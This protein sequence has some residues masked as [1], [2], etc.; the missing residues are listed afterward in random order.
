MIG[1]WNPAEQIAHPVKNPD[2]QR[3]HNNASDA[4]DKIKGKFQ[5]M[6]KL[7]EWHIEDRSPYACDARID[8]VGNNR[9]DEGRHQCCRLKFSV[10]IKNFD[11]KKRSSQRRAKDG[12]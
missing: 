4:K 12:A 8:R 1:N 11:G 2:I 10:A 3:T 6:N 9:G 7:K 5:W